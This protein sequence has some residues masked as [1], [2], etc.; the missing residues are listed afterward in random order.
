MIDFQLPMIKSNIFH[1]LSLSLFIFNYPFLFFFFNLLSI[2]HYLSPVNF[3][4]IYY[5]WSLAKWI[6]HF[7]KFSNDNDVRSRSNLDSFKFISLEQDCLIHQII[8]LFFIYLFIFFFF[9]FYFS[10]KVLLLWRFY[11]WEDIINIVMH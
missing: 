6:N 7:F 2:F 9:A 4:F 5:W 8:R 11:Y 3:F 10:I 1:P